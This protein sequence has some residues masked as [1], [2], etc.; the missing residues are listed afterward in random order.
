[1]S[2]ERIILVMAVVKEKRSSGELIPAK[3]LLYSGSQPNLITDE[4]A[5]LLLSI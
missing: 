5:Q 2:Y 1:M 4:L 3:A